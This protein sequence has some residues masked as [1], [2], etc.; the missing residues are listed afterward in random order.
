MSYHCHSPHFC[1][2]QPKDSL[3]YFVLG[4]LLSCV[5][6]WNDGISLELF[7][8]YGPDRFAWSTVSVVFVFLIVII[9]LGILRPI[10]IANN[11]YIKSLL[12]LMLIVLAPILLSSIRLYGQTWSAILRRPFFFGGYLIFPILILLRLSK[13]ETLHFFWGLII[14]SLIATSLTCL[15]YFEPDLQDIFVKEMTWVRFGK[16]RVGGGRILPNLSMILFFVSIAGFIDASRGWVRIGAFFN[17][18]VMFW[19]FFY[20]WKTRGII[21][22]LMVTLIVIWLLQLE[23]RNR[24]KVLFAV[25]FVLICS[26]V[27]SI[28][29][30]E[31]PLINPLKQLYRLSMEEY[32]AY[33]GTIG[34]RIEAIRYYFTEFKRTYFVGVGLTSTTANTDNPISIGLLYYGLNMN[35]I[36][37]LGMIYKFGVPVIIFLFVMFRRLLW[38]LSEL[39]LRGQREVRIIATGIMFFLVFNIAGFFFTK[40]FFLPKFSLFY[41]LL[42]SFVWRLKQ[43]DFVT[44]EKKG[45]VLALAET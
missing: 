26:L 25:G 14:L 5:F 27:Y 36:G 44:E 22:P 6:F 8:F 17:A 29:A 20:V 13:K 3:R 12:W 41:G 18:L 37:I 43:P 7:N 42:L 2:S 10:N 31:F 1:S 9:I 33:G 39:R 35:D 30:G 24:M 40:A 34:S 23:L 11:W 45:S 16:L 21:F 38:D 19:M 15:V 4:F 28:F 32:S